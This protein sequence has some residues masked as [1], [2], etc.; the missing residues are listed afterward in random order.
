MGTRVHM[1][2]AALVIGLD[3]VLY[4]FGHDVTS[5]FVAL[6]LVS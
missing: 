3:V 1:S 6:G 4:F 2:L 5:H